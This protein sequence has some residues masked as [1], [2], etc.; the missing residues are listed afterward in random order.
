MTQLLLIKTSSMG[1]V[2]HMLPA[3]SDIQRHRP[4]VQVDWVVEEAFAAIPAWHPQ[5]RR[6]IPVALRRWR[7]QGWWKAQTRQEWQG[8]TRDVQHAHYDAVLDTQGLLKSAWLAC[9]AR[10]K[11]YGYDRRSIREPLASIAYQRHFVV[12]RQLHAITRNR[13]LT[14]QTLG[15]DIQHTPLDYGIAQQ[16]FTTFPALVGIDFQRTAYVLALHG[17]SRVEKEWQETQWQAL[18]A[19][20][21]AQGVAVLLPW[22]NAREFE[23]AQRLAAM[24]PMVQ[25]LPRC[26]LLELASVLQHARAV[27]GMD[28]GL[29]HLAAALNQSGFALYPVTQPDLTGVCGNAAFPKT[30]HSI[31][32]ADT[33]DTAGVIQR[34][35]AVLSTESVPDLTP[36][37]TATL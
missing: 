22:G 30:L 9:C 24:N 7:K 11:R 18:C 29:M 28:T 34:L 32:G 13:L 6:V 26:S 37:T 1:D 2:I 36:P 35:L 19:A 3:L 14:A 4:A 31:A 16:T 23:R 12:S 17:T 15:Y 21:T 8:F 25:V 27:I 10:G 33:H 20:V 5:V